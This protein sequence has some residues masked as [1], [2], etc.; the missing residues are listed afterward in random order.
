MGGENAVVDDEVDVGVGAQGGDGGDFAR[1]VGC[2]FEDTDAEWIAA[3]DDVGR[4][5]SEIGADSGISVAGDGAAAVGDEKAVRDRRSN[6]AGELL[7]TRAPGSSEE[8]AD[9]NEGG[10]KEELA[11][12]G[13]QMRGAECGV[14]SCGVEWREDGRP[15][16]MW[17]WSVGNALVSVSAI[18]WG[19]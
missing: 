1:G 13:E 3:A 10:D 4:G 14:G 18:V 16:E 8:D 7:G 11:Q 15:R 2:G 17:R 6:G 19:G 9:E 12:D 5:S